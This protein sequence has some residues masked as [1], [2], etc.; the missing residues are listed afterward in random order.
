MGMVILVDTSLSMRAGDTWDEAR[1]R[2]RNVLK[3]LPEDSPVALIAF[4]RNPRVLVSETRNPAR[5]RSELAVVK[6]G[7][8]ATDLGAALRAGAEIGNQ[9]NSRRT[10]VVL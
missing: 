1:M 7:Y 6:P 10:R 8:G 3:T 5:V 4:D 9:L 2:A